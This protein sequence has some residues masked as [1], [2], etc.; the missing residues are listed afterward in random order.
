M[1]GGKIEAMLVCKSMGHPHDENGNQD[2]NDFTFGKCISSDNSTDK[3]KTGFRNLYGSDQG[4]NYIN[5]E[6]LIYNNWILVGTT[7]WAQ[8][9]YRY[10]QTIFYKISSD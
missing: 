5:I 10:T 6:E 9:T 3:F 2:M 4:S 8:G 1:G 7:W